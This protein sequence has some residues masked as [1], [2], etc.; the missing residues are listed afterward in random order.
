MKSVLPALP[1]R[2]W[3]TRSRSA[4]ETANRR[5]CAGEA[6]AGWQRF[7]RT[8]RR[9][10]PTP[11][12]APSETNAAVPAARLKSL[13]VVL[14]AALASACTFEAGR[15]FA[16]LESVELE[17]RF[18]PGEHAV[19]GGVLTD[20]GYLVRLDTITLELSELELATFDA[21]P[22]G[23]PADEP[24]HCHDANCEPESEAEPEPE[25]EQRAEGEVVAILPVDRGVD[26]LGE[27]RLVLTQVE[28]SSELG[29]VH[30]EQAELRVGRIELSG[31]VSEG[32]L[33]A[34]VPLSVSVDLDAHVTAAVDVAVTHDG[35]EHLSLHGA[36]ALEGALFDAIDFAADD[37][38]AV[39][40]D[41][42]RAEA[43]R[44]ALTEALHL[45]FEL[46]PH[47]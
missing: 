43:L 39:D 45:G 18:E 41:D 42:E 10:E 35:P 38:F 14:A 37:S 33:T 21:E 22:A 16:T 11:E 6:N 26:V 36:L 32:G 12:T 34:E 9:I 47:P 2:S 17:T 24:A 31:V 8:A 5:D 46:E 13:T 4:S 23:A 44:S 7:G 15:G 3:T 29:E 19:E 1:P 28:P 30:L 25:P 20:L 27:E 40:D